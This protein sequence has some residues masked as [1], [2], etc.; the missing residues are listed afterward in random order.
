MVMERLKS[1][2]PGFCDI[3]GWP[4]NPTGTSFDVN[5]NLAVFLQ[6]NYKNVSDAW[7]RD[8]E[9]NDKIKT[10]RNGIHTAHRIEEQAKLL[11]IHH[12]SY[13]NKRYEPW[14]TGEIINDKLRA[15]AP[16]VNLRRGFMMID[17]AN[18]TIC[19]YYR[20]YNR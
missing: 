5:A 11:Q 20:D 15:R 17:D 6:D 9:T 19:R 8:T 7:G 12:S 4:D 13:S 18:S 10:L 16:L 3:S 1:R 14:A 2:V